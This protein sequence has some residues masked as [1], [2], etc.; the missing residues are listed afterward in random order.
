LA[1][2]LFGILHWDRA[3]KPFVAHLA[4]SVLMVV[5]AWSLVWGMIQSMGMAATPDQAAEIQALQQELVLRMQKGEITQ[6]QAEQELRQALQGIMTRQ[7]YQSPALAGSA[8]ASGDAVAEPTGVDTDPAA[9]DAKI[10]EAMAREDA[11]REQPRVVQS[12]PRPKPVQTYVAKDPQ[13]ARADI[14]KTVSLTTRNGQERNGGLI[15]VSAKGELLVERRL[16]GGSAVYT[17]DPA[18]VADYK[19]LEWVQR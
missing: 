16:H 4:S 18:L 12:P 3:A 11:L 14:G 13:G 5:L 8:P 10:A 7:P 19:V 9:L 17:V 6:Q 15:D 2:L 1:T